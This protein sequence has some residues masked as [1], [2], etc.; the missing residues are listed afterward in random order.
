MD[1]HDWMRTESH[2]WD[3]WRCPAI[4]QT[5]TLT[6]EYLKHAIL[7]ELTFICISITLDIMGNL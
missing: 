3:L 7:Y 5:L 2:Y 1:E 4:Q 6:G